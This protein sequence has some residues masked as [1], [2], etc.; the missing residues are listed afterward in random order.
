MS[1]I[2]LFL[3]VLSQMVAVMVGYYKPLPALFDAAVVYG[4][5]LFFIKN[6]LGSESVV[7]ESNIL[8]PLIAAFHVVK[9]LLLCRSQF[10]ERYY[11]LHYFSV[12]L[13]ITYLV[14]AAQF[15]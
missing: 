9:Y 14:V 15:I 10:S 4:S 5:P 1:T 8:F 11:S 13:E 3:M 2:F 7:L 12:I 6:L